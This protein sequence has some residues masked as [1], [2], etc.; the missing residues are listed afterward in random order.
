MNKAYYL[1]FI[2]F[3]IFVLVLFYYFIENRQYSKIVLPLL[4]EQLITSGLKNKN[5]SPAQLPTGYEFSFLEF[6]K[7]EKRL[8]S[9][10]SDDQIT[11]ALRSVEHVPL[12][13][14]PIRDNVPLEILDILQAG[15]WSKQIHSS[16]Y[17]LNRIIQILG[18]CKQNQRF[19][20]DFIGYIIEPLPNKLSDL[21][22]LDILGTKLNCL[23]QLGVIANESAISFLHFIIS[24]EEL[25][26]FQKEI[27]GQSSDQLTDKSDY[28]KHSIH[29]TATLALIVA[30]DKLAK[31]MIEREYL[32]MAENGCL[33]DI[34]YEYPFYFEDSRNKS[35]FLGLSNALATRDYIQQYGRQA[36]LEIINTDALLTSIYIIFEA[37]ADIPC[38]NFR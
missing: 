18:M 10:Y 15:L 6:T 17:D 32:E 1:T 26:I 30:Q 29:K 33:K 35:I 11:E 25:E 21:E 37:Y 38:D 36:Y 12:Q 5:A 22:F 3:L 7:D 8:P 31:E 28:L 13:Y 24:N 27:A 14:N 2:L 20:N 23:N 9:N 19:V 34:T 16:L 4:S